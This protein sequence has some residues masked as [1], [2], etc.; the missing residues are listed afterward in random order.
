MPLV[1]SQI[2]VYGIV[3]SGYEEDFASVF[4]R[5]TMIAGGPL[6]MIPCGGI[7]AIASDLSLAE[8]NELQQLGEDVARAREWVLAHH[9]TL[10]RLAEHHTMLPL[11]FGTLFADDVSLR[12]ELET[13]Y[14]AITTKL[15]RV[16]GA[17]E[18]GL[19]VFCD[20]GHIKQHLAEASATVSD[21]RR[22]IASAGEGTAF[23]LARRMERLADSEIDRT[24][25]H[26]LQVIRQRLTQ[27]VRE[28]VAIKIQPPQVHGR[29]M[30]M[31]ANYAC[32]VP[33]EAD[34]AFANIVEDLCSTFG[35]LGYV[36]EA[37]GPWPAYSFVEESLGDS[38]N[39]A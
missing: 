21:L 29:D 20:R 39:A 12:A 16:S 35:S 32:L 17:R 33:R 19:K 34:A 24:I 10:D 9:Q 22:Q 14:T 1:N 28:V 7:A 38:A 26:H 23:F 8:S 31:I 13:R 3:P 30:T 2:Y 4:D 36:Y 25:A 27:T 18:W 37:T 11:R 5:I 6:R 15:D